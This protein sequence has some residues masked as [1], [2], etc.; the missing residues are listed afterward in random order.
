MMLQYENLPADSFAPVFLI[1]YWRCKEKMEVTHAC[2]FYC[3]FP[4]L[5][6]GQS[7]TAYQPFFN[8]VFSFAAFVRGEMI[9]GFPLDINIGD[10]APRARS[11][12][13][14]IAGSG[15]KFGKLGDPLGVAV[16]QDG[17]VI[18]SDSRN[19]RL[20]VSVVSRHRPASSPGQFALCE[21]A[22]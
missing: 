7:Y 12:K 6:D 19:H 15:S 8:G 13:K 14:A 20:Q 11:A 2:A 1:M 9:E 22:E 5:D 16:D 21:R 10:I 18:V 4:F 17:H 3:Y